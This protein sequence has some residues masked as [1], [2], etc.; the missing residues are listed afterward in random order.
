[1]SLRWRIAAVLAGVAV[2]VGALAAVGA[3]I[4][5]AN[6][7]RASLDE[8]LVSRAATLNP[9]GGP[10]HGREPGGRGGPDNA[11]PGGTGCPEAGAFRPATAAQLVSRDGTVTPCIPGAPALPAD[12]GDLAVTGGGNRLRTASVDG[13]DYRIL[14]TAWPDGR[15]LQI[16][17]SLRETSDV[18]SVLRLRLAALVGGGVALAAFLGWLIARRIA[19]PIVRLRDTAEVIATTQDLTTPIPTS[20]S[21]EIGSLARSFTAM[22]AALAAS[23]E[24]QQ[25]LVSDASHEMRTP[26]TSITSNLELLQRV[27]ELPP[28]ERGEVLAAVG[29]DV[30]ELTHLVAELVELATDP[31]TEDEPLEPL[32]LAD[33]A[34]D[35]AQRAERRSGR[36]ISVAETANGTVLA[37][38]HMVERAI[39]NLV[40]NAVKYSPSD[41]PI[42][43]TV[44]GGRL[45]VRDHG[46]GIAPE[47]VP[48]VFDRFYRATS[49]RTEPGSGLGLAIVQ[50]IV[51]RHNG[52][53]LVANHP[54]GGA[55]V[56]F[57]LS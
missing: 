41:S 25:R 36:P 42:E 54:D 22:V 44:D 45:E 6:Q 24:Q 48:H 13:E 23:R 4:S 37:R 30:R 20:G 15:V 46:D 3:Y 17:R 31:S 49:A 40:E 19:R 29:I 26:L 32:R 10:N 53:V 33:M 18:L 38:P 14:T 50:Q 55:V 21:G 47:D 1:V 51:Q 39:S 7:L 27:S 9:D 56:G 28:D 57:E 34:R 11:A 16:A 35:V 52:R 43:I 12:A 8:S 5:T 2:L